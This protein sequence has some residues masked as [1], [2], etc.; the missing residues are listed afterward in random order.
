MT[1]WAPLM[2]CQRW[3]SPPVELMSQGYQMW[4]CAT[5][6]TLCDSKKKKKEAFSWS[7]DW[8]KRER[9]ERQSLLRSFQSQVLVLVMYCHM[10]P[11]GVLPTTCCFPTLLFLSPEDVCHCR[12]TLQKPFQSKLMLI[13]ALCVRLWWDLT[14]L[15]PHLNSTVGSGGGRSTLWW[16]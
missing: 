15:T 11:A 14:G 4:G 10:Y 7:M 2:V 3:L 8:N 9:E 13:H 12:E 1:H 5:Q 16:Q 6:R